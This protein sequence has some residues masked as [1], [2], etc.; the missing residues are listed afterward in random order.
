MNLIYHQIGFSDDDATR[1][2]VH[3]TVRQMLWRLRN[4]TDNGPIPM[5]GPMRFIPVADSERGRKVMEVL[6][7]L[8]KNKILLF[9]HVNKSPA[10]LFE[11]FVTNRYKLDLLLAEAKWLGESKEKRSNPPKI[12][13]LV[14]YDSKSGRGLVNGNT[15]YLRGRNKKVFK[16]L[17]VSA[18]NPVSK[19]SLQ[20]AVMIGHKSDDKKQ[21][22][23]DAF[24]ALRK[25]CKVDKSVIYLREDGGRLNAKVFPLSVQLFE[26]A[27]G[28]EAEQ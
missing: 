20:G 18:P 2:N 1:V 26:D 21:A 13:N 19:D 14:Y 22:M 4:Y 5:D 7:V 27:F 16:H 24:S 23:N 10:L 15:V 9:R 6:E 17:F 3:Y 28:T 8:E 11:I 12:D 25:A